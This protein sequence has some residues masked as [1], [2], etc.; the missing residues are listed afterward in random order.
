MKIQ[1]LAESI[2]S[3]KKPL[4]NNQKKSFI[5]LVTLDEGDYTSEQWK[6]SVNMIKATI[7]KSESRIMKDSKQKI[8]KVIEYVQ[9]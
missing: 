2:L 9:N 3:L 5:V 7:S 4:T 8:D 1:I 6:G